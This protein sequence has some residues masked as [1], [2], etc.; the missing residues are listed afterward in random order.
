MKILI[1]ILFSWILFSCNTHE[2]VKFEQNNI[3]HFKINNSNIKLNINVP[4]II[5]NV[6][7]IALESGENC[8]IGSV[9]LIRYYDKK[10][11]ILDKNLTKSLFVFTENGAFLFKIKKQG[12]G[13][14]EYLMLNGF[15]LDIKGNIYLG[16]KMKQTIIMYDPNGN[17]IKEFKTNIYFEDFCSLP[18]GK[19]L[20][21][22]VSEN[23][24]VETML[25]MLNLETISLTTIIKGRKFFDDLDIPRFNTANLFKSDSTVVINPRFSNKIYKITGSLI[26]NFIEVDS[27]I[28]P[29]KSFIEK[30]KN[31]IKVLHESKYVVDIGSIYETSEFITL[32]IQEKFPMNYIISKKT[33][34]NIC[35]ATFSKI[36]YLGNNRFYGIMENKFISLIEPTV[37]EYNWLE[38]I[39]L[40]NLDECYKDLLKQYDDTMNPII[41]LVEFESF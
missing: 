14:G 33:S 12:G 32:R 36:N 29:P 30:F 1:I 34:N 35:T 20:V 15:D 2:K 18:N 3:P 39:E 37:L 26:T 13:P 22:N 11:Y 21:Q 7:Y 19:L 25:G 40:S 27:T 41:C 6:D 38:N 4:N 16:D 23:G 24:R 28:I 31:D 8:L 9:D 5:K 10:I 17:F